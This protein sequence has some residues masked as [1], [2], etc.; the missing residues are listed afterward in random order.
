MPLNIYI[1][2]SNANIYEE[3]A[4]KQTEGSFSGTK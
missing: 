3:N 1:F 4:N 2:A